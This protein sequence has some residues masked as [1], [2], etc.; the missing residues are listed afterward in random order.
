MY[1]DLLSLVLDSGFQVVNAT[2]N[3]SLYIYRVSDGQEIYSGLID[4]FGASDGIVITSGYG[5]TDYA[6]FNT[7]SDCASY[8]E[9][10]IES[11]ATLN[12]FVGFVPQTF[13]ISTMQNAIVQ[14][15]S[16]Y[17]FSA[18]TIIS[19]TLAIGLAYLVFRFGWRKLKRVLL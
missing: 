13:T 10:F 3:T 9:C 4:S 8:S 5:E 15:T 6:F 19:L 7:P 11:T 1:I 2:P 12:H 16:E 14:K 18:L 17:G